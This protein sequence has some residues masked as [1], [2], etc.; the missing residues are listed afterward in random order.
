MARPSSLPEWASTAGPSDLIEPALLKKQSGWRKVI[1]GVDSIPEKPPYQEFNWWQ[2]LVY[3]WVVYWADLTD[4]EFTQLKNID[5][6]TISNTQWGYISGFNQ[7]LTITS[8]VIFNSVESGEVVTD[9]INEQTPGA[10]VTV[11]GVLLKDGGASFDTVETDVLSEKTL[12]EGVR[13]DG[14]LIKDGFGGGFEWFSGLNA[15]EGVTL[16]NVERAFVQIGL[17]PVRLT[18]STTA[19][20][21]Y[22]PLGKKFRVDV[23]GATPTNF[24]MLRADTNDAQEIA[25]MTSDGYIEAY[26][27]GGGNPNSASDWVVVKHSLVNPGSTGYKQITGAS[28]SLNEFSPELIDVSLA[29]GSFNFSMPSGDI[30][31]GRIFKFN[32]TGGAVNASLSSSVFGLYSLNGG[33]LGDVHGNGSITIQAVVDNPNGSLTD[34]QWK[35]LEQI[36][37]GYRHIYAPSVNNFNHTIA[38]PKII[39]VTNPTGVINVRLSSATTAGPIRAGNV[40]KLIVEGATESNYVALQATDGSTHVEIDRIGGDGFIEVMALQNSP[41]AVSHWVIVSGQ[42]LTGTF[43]VNATGAVTASSTIE[44][45]R[46]L[47]S[48]MHSINVVSTTS[49]TASATTDITLPSI[50]PSR[51]RPS[52]AVHGGSVALSNGRNYAGS[53]TIGTNGSIAFYITDSAV[54]NYGGTSGVRPQ[55]ITYKK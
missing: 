39:K 25:R 43:S 31:A 7:A 42:E 40:F 9:T 2:N 29:G 24:L 6:N 51:L 54:T 37:G 22:P 36:S 21:L 3:K 48:K 53:F 47:V 15:T 23:K 14:Y 46:C 1:V 27:S 10:G 5:T 8:D 41:T 34:G 16:H 33:F 11:D 26:Y 18:F 13:V 30:K 12:G 50:I 35:L 44:I 45:S 55:T 32:V 38:Q 19:P 49:A 17:T 4:V 28:D 52:Q 20:A